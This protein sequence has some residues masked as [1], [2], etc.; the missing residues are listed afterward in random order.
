MF[1]GLKMLRMV[2]AC[3]GSWILVFAVFDE[4]PKTVSMSAM[5]E[6]L[7]L[8]RRLTGNR[9]VRGRWEF[10]WPRDQ[11]LVVA[12]QSAKV[13]KYLIAMDE[14]QRNRINLM[15][16]SFAFLYGDAPRRCTGCK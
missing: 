15:Y 12:D 8:L 10:S 4:A 2:I 14:A 11:E 1:G 16:N 7:S 9:P 6:E 13:H 5:T 3:F